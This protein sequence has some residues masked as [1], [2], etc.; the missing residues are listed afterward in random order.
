MR[1]YGR[2]IILS[3]SGVSQAT[4]LAQFLKDN[5]IH[6]STEILIE[7][8]FDG[9]LLGCPLLSL[10]IIHGHVDIL[11]IVGSNPHFRFVRCLMQ[12]R[13]GS[14]CSHKFLGCYMR[15]ADNTINLL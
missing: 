11:G 15:A 7:E 1:V 5:S 4:C 9:S 10:I 6:A 12:I 14:R 3:S 2:R 8:R 13:L